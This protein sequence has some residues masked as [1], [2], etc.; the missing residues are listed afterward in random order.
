MK[1]TVL[2]STGF[3][4]SHVA[5]LARSQGHDIYCPSRRDSLAGRDLGHVIYA[6]GMTADFRHRPHETIEAHEADVENRPH[7]TIEA[8]VTKLQE[9]LKQSSFE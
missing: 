8:H 6:I 2:G 4:G 5:A 7:E 9:V 3:I 1:F